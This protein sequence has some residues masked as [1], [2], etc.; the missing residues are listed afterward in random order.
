MSNAPIAPRGQGLNASAT[1]MTNVPTGPRGGNPRGRSGGH[2]GRGG[3]RFQPHRP[4][5][6]DQPNSHQPRLV[7]T[8][9][10]PAP[11]TIKGDAFVSAPE[12]LTGKTLTN[13]YG[14]KFPNDDVNS[15]TTG[16]TQPH[17]PSNAASTT[18]TR[19][20]GP[21]ATTPV[22]FSS[23]TGSPNKAS[24]GSSPI[25]SPNSRKSPPSRGASSAQSSGTEGFQEKI[26]Q[27]KNGEITNPAPVQSPR[28]PSKQTIRRIVFLLIKDLHSR[29]DMKGTAVASDYHKYLVTCQQLP[30]AAT[31]THQ[32]ILY[33]DHEHHRGDYP[34]YTVTIDV[35]PKKLPINSLLSLLSRKDDL[36]E[37]EKNQKHETITALNV[38]FTNAASVKTFTDHLPNSGN[39]GSIQTVA[40]SGSK[41]F[42]DLMPLWAEDI[43]PQQLRGNDKYGLVGRLGFFLSTRAFLGANKIFLNINTTRSAFHHEGSLNDYIDFLLRPVVNGRTQDDTLYNGPPP[44][45]DANSREQRNPPPRS[46]WTPDWDDAMRAIGGLKVCTAYHNDARNSSRSNEMLYTVCQLQEQPSVDVATAGDAVTSDPLVN[47]AEYFGREYSWLNVSPEDRIV[48]VRGVTS[49]RRLDAEPLLIPARLL[50]LIPGQRVSSKVEMID[51]AVRPP[52]ANRDKIQ[53]QGRQ[54]FELERTNTNLA[55][56]AAFAFGGLRVEPDMHELDMTIM[57]GPDLVYPTALPTD[58]GTLNDK[59]RASGKWNLENR[60]FSTPAQS[61]CWT[62]LRIFNPGSRRPHLSEFFASVQTELPKYGLKSEAFI[63]G[64]P[65]SNFRGNFGDDSFGDLHSFDRRKADHK[66]G[67]Q[68]RTRLKELF[69]APTGGKTRLVFVILPFKDSKIYQQVKR[70]A[71]L[72][73]I[74]TICNFSYFNQPKNQSSKVTNMLMKFNLKMERDTVNQKFRSIEPG[75]LGCIDS[76]TML[77]GMDVTHPPVGAMDEAP[78]I[79]ALVGSVNKEFSQFPAVLRE[80]PPLKDKRA[81]EEIMKL[82]EMVQLSVE[83][84]S[85][86]NLNAMP[87]RIIAF[88]DGLSEDQLEMCKEAEIPRIRDGIKAVAESL[89]SKSI[90]ELF[91]ICTI[92]R[93]HV[94]FF[95]DPKVNSK[96]HDGKKSN[97][98]PGAMVDKDVVLEA[99]RHEFFLVSHEAIQGTARPCHY[100]PICL[101]ETAT[102]DT[103]DLARMT[104]ALCF[105][106]GRSTRSVSLATPSYYADLAA[107]RARC[108]VRHIYEP[109][110]KE[111]DLLQGPLVQIL[112]DEKRDGCFD[113]ICYDQPLFM[114]TYFSSTIREEFPASHPLLHSSPHP[115][116]V[117]TA[118]RLIGGGA[119][120]IKDLVEW[121]STCCHHKTIVPLRSVINCPARFVLAVDGIQRLRIDLLVEETSQ[122]LSRLQYELFEVNTVVEIFAAGHNLPSEVA[123]A[124]CQCV[125]RYFFHGSLPEIDKW[126]HLATMNLKFDDGVKAWLRPGALNEGPDM[127]GAWELWNSRSAL[128]YPARWYQPPRAGPSYERL[129][130]STPYPPVHPPHQRGP[131]DAYPSAGYTSTPGWHGPD[132]PPSP[133]PKPDAYRQRPNLAHDHHDYSDPP[134][135]IIDVT[136]AEHSQ[137]T[138]H[139]RLRIGATATVSTNEQSIGTSVQD[140]QVSLDLIANGGLRIL[141]KSGMLPMSHHSR[142]SVFVKGVNSGQSIMFTSLLISMVVSEWSRKVEMYL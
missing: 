119:N 66:D 127:M 42:F 9:L 95:K 97:P 1:S 86:N 13:H 3:G 23:G 29:G 116:Q 107:D 7:H 89:G 77:M 72:E 120:A 50:T 113:L 75:L 141:A 101:P 132:A 109:E 110:L 60:Q 52:D 134:T 99:G 16:P 12:R 133:P 139:H 49:R 24:S 80:N 14:I 129:R 140:L 47:V 125:A 114:L 90:P 65:I 123:N 57:N 18:L 112:L 5:I 122:L 130:P 54:L 55:P 11:A 98:L 44:Q 36:M 41:K 46:E 51:F 74:Q 64:Q 43:G 70:A 126:L 115:Q 38:V 131:G 53:K 118:V 2:A 111:G 92:K 45:P 121:M 93:H 81:R 63:N 61:G 25:K 103:K 21:G 32:V 79:A 117:P 82:K 35:D 56:A 27:E 91:V 83:R 37:K 34:L 138:A 76:Q 108:W 10:E 17:S 39:T 62:V 105:L 104:H 28:N 73:G 30:L 8:Q 87:K 124:I 48:A 20:T 68:L 26:E 88:R 31:T 135:G 137:S 128:T 78:S 96:V 6:I 22:R 59:E 142:A 84:W 106:F 40:R 19:R 94:R 67:E 33:G 4:P 102:I 85:K 71:D 100:V 15:S 69:N 136:L 58:K